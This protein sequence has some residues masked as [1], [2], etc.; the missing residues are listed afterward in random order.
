M[1]GKIGNRNEVNGESMKIIGLN[2]DC[3]EQIF[4]YGKANDL[5][6]LVET[7]GRIKIAAANSF[8]VNYRTFRV[9]QHRAAYQDFKIVG[10]F[11]PF[12]HSTI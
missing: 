11:G 2:D 8:K 7:S 5:V 1:S 10:H 4:L 6:N 12:F 3:L 9:H